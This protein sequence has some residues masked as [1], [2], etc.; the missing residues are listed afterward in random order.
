MF[1]VTSKKNQAVET[2][3]EKDMPQKLETD[4]YVYTEG[5]TYLVKKTLDTILYNPKLRE[6]E[7]CNNSWI[8]LQTYSLFVN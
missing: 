4:S 2:V 7:Y 6:K 1:I 8:Q 3:A 5:V